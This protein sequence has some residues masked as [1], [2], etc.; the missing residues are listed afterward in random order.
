MC[1][2]NGGGERTSSVVAPGVGRRRTGRRLLLMHVQGR[3]GRL[4]VRMM[5]WLLLLLVEGLMLVRVVVMGVMRLRRVAFGQLLMMRRTRGGKWSRVS[6][7]VSVRLLRVD[8]IVSTR[9]RS[10]RQELHAP[11]SSTLH[12]FPATSRILH[13]LLAQKHTGSDTCCT[14]AA[15]TTA[16]AVESS[17]TVPP[18]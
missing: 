12:S 9:N 7:V 11:D 17:G 1:D 18:V 8:D 3:R 4:G 5:R 13:L 2:A 15:E 10:Q 6:R 14:A 16:S